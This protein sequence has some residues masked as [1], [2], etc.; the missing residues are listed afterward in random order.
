MTPYLHAEQIEKTFAETTVLESVDIPVERGQFV[1]LIGPSGS[2]KTTTLRIIAGTETP[3]AGRV[4]MDGRDITMLPA[5]RRGFAMVF[6][7][8]ALFPHKDV[9]ENIAYGLR[10]RGKPKAEIKRRVLEMLDRVGLETHASR[11]VNELSGGQ[12]QRVAL[13]R[14]LVI[15]PQLLLL[16]EPTGSLD[17]KLRLHMQSELKRLHADFD[18]TV[19]HV[20]HNQSEALALANRVFVM[21]L[22]RIEQSGTPAEVFNYPETRFVAEFV[23]LNNLIDGTARNQRVTTP[24]GELPLDGG[25]ATHKLVGQCT[26]VIRSDSIHV[27]GAVPDGGFSVEAELEALEYQG[28]IVRW[29]LQAGE[30]SLRADLRA[31]E[32]SRLSP[33]IGDRYQVWWRPDDVHFLQN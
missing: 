26:A 8:F 24:L 10:L 30:V 29:F 28:S 14:A 19:V 6:Q 18:L 25:P 22:G 17:A 4:T 33:A 9:F 12:R 13:A 1:S 11:D 21:H 31:E 5:H 23:G 27:D 32:T 7:H 3:T 20:T 15:E 2:G 16:D